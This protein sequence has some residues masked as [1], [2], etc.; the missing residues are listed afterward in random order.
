MTA[1][2]IVISNKRDLGQTD[3][4]LTLSQ[5]FSGC[6]SDSRKQES[7]S[8]NPVRRGVVQEPLRIGQIGL[9]R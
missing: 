5:A 4:Y 9:N 6:S 7:G 3:H 2:A 1:M 8:E